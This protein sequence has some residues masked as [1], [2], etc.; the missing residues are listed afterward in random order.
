MF[1]D[2]RREREAD[3]HVAC[4]I[5]PSRHSHIPSVFENITN[6]E[7]EETGRRAINRVSGSF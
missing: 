7:G 1:L 4:G 6:K 3:I 2:L 5:F